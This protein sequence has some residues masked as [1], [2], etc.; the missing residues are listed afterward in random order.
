[1]LLPR[2]WETADDSCWY[3]SHH[4]VRR[5]V[6]GDDSTGCD[7]SAGSDGDP[8]EDSHSRAYSGSVAD[9]DPREGDLPRTSIRS[10]HRVGVCDE[11]GERSDVAVLAERDIR[12]NI[13]VTVE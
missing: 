9:R 6:L 8:S 11:S 5:H 3:A 12:T 13:D 1:M 7:H 10:A 2:T 4:C